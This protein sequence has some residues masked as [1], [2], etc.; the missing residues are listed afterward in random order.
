MQLFTTLVSFVR[1]YAKSTMRP[2]LHMKGRFFFRLELVTFWGMIKGIGSRRKMAN[3][4]MEE[5]KG[6]NIVNSVTDILFERCLFLN[7]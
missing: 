4:D 3:C 2:E 1:K 7:N 5:G 6:V